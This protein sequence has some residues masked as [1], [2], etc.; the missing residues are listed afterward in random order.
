M[1]RDLGAPE[2]VLGVTRGQLALDDLATIRRVGVDLLE[3]ARQQVLLLSQDLDPRVYDHPPFLQGLQRLA[4]MRGSRARIR[5]L[6]LDNHRLI[7][8]SHRLLSLTQHLTTAIELRRPIAEYRERTDEFL[9]FDQ[10][11]YVYREQS[12][13]ARAVASY[14]DPL[15]ARR[16]QGKFLEIW[17]H[18]EPDPE[19]RR[20]HL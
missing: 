20:L 12:E 13:T 5:I 6:I 17:E 4:I 19:I 9:L 18:S 8:G 11:A 7:K 2:P 15:T 10:S 16:L 1:S 14:H 3:Q